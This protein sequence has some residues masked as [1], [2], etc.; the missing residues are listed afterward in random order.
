MRVV[1]VFTLHLCETLAAAAAT[2]CPALLFTP[3]NVSVNTHDYYRSQ[4]AS[5]HECRITRSGQTALGLAERTHMLIVN[6]GV[7]IFA[8]AIDR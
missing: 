2:G 7:H 4:K 3:A 8:T 1:A 5:R 6:L